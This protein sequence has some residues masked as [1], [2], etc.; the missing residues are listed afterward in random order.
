M[1]L[2]K[3]ANLMALGVILTLAAAG[4]RHSP[5]GT[6]NIPGSK[7]GSP[8][9]VANTNPLE[10]NVKD[11]TNAFP[12][13]DPTK[14]ADYKP[15]ATILASDTAYFAFDSSVVRES[16]KSKLTAVGDYLKANPANALRVEGHCDE[17]GT[18]EYNRSLGERRALALREALINLGIDPNKILTATF[19]KDRPAV[20]GHDE[21]AWSKNR[22]GEFIVLLPPAK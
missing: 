14:Y 2:I 20:E 8:G 13:P 21:A 16:E 5:E 7:T 10:P 1:K 12:L 18:E 6:K 9:D 3:F 4:C 11:M 15:D 22:R 17:R 19:G